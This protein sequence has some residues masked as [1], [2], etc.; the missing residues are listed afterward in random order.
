MGSEGH[1]VLAVD[2]KQTNLLMLETILQSEGYQVVT[3]I[4][5]AQAWEC[6]QHEGSRFQAVLLDRI[7]PLMSGLDV[8]VKMKAHPELKTIPVIMQTTADAPHEV[9]EGIQAG[10]YYYLTKPYQKEVLLAIVQAA[11]KDYLNHQS[12]REEIHKSARTLG[13]LESGIFRFRTLTEAREL[14]PLVAN[15]FPNPERVVLG[16]GE[17]LVNAVEHGNLQISY[18]EKS[19]LDK[20]DRLDTEIERRLTMPEHASKFVDV[21]FVRREGCLEL[22]VTDQGEGFDWQAYLTLDE[23]RAFDS[24]G[25]G[26]AMARMMSFDMLE[27]RGNGN[28]VVCTVLHSPQT[29][30]ESALAVGAMGD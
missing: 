9:L 24:H 25:R 11:I 10:A 3:A 6:L 20:D 18:E 12:L 8:L 28:Q 7:M 23:H 5:G 29:V 4:N 16:L 2:D 26:I 1:A 30:P 19:L 15:G 14:A 22:T 27:Y 13:F 17:L 21:T